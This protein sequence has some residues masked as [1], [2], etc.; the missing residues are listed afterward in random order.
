MGN[1]VRRKLSTVKKEQQFPFFTW[2]FEEEKFRDL[3]TDAKLLYCLLKHR[4]EYSIENNFF[5]ENGD[6]YVVYTIAQIMEKL[7]CREQKSVKLKKELKDIG[8]IE[9]V[10]QGLKEANIIYVN[11]YISA[12]KQ[13][14]VLNCENH[15]SGIV[16]I[17]N[18]ELRKSQ[19]KN[20]ENHKQVYSIG[21]CEN[22]KQVLNECMNDINNQSFNDFNNDFNIVNEDDI[23]KQ[24]KY[25]EDGSIK[26]YLSSIAV[27][28]IFQEFLNTRS[29]KLTMQEIIVAVK[30][31]EPNAELVQM[32]M[33]YR[34]INNKWRKIIPF[35]R[36]DINDLYFPDNDLDS[37]L[38]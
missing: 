20:C 10:R 15:N 9:E 28:E 25:Y 6:V 37:S 24:F 23:S 1:L 22:H 2:L 26:Q 19:I 18:Q 11:D 32:D 12:E 21:N 5:D 38:N 4:E 13:E 16:K 30:I 35:S 36:E 31:L 29:K 33:I 14:A 27:D 8:L 17:T 3:S 34:S 7:N